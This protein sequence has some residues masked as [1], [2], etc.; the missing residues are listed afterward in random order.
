LPQEV[1]VI[2]GGLAGLSAAVVLAESGFHVTVLERRPFL[3]GRASSYPIDNAK[4]EFIDNCQHVVLKSCTNLL[5]FYRKLGTEKFITYSDHLIFLDTNGKRTLLKDSILPAP[6]HLLPSLLQFS[7][8][9]F[10]DRTSIAS[11][12]YHMLQERHRTDLDQITMLEWLRQHKQSEQAIQS[13][14]REIL[15]SAI[16]EEIEFASAKYGV[17]VFLDGV[18]RNSDAFHF[19]VPSVP[20]EQL[21]TEP[22]IRFLSEKGCGV[23]LRTSVKQIDIQSNAVQRVVL[24]D[25]SELS[26]DYYIC[27]VTPDVLGN[28]MPGSF[29]DLQQLGT[30]PITSVY[31]WFDQEITDLPFAGFIGRQMQ[32]MFRKS[33]SNGDYIGLVVSASR[34][35]LPLG[36]NEIVEIAMQDLRELF[37]AIKTAKLQRAAVLK[38]PYAT[39][40]CRPGCDALR[41]DQKTEIDRFYLAGDW[42]NTGWP[43]TMEGAVRSGYRCAELILTKE[44]INRSVMQPDLPFEGLSRWFK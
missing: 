15:V 11:A 5:D 17:Q 38:E 9:S 30:S 3:G 20:L 8:L 35:L 41:P 28:L 2:G 14:W 40:S 31:L 24:N 37:P 23:R 25:G 10:G 1:L 21:Y 32:W 16:N 26:A 7:P 13:F 44:G 36:R 27:S 43:P 34:N 39:F 12:F 29:Q 19:G 6:I 22:C 33:G 18:L 4:E 42:T